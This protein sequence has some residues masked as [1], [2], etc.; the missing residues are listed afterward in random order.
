MSWEIHWDCSTCGAKI[1]AQGEQAGSVVLCPS[2]CT[3]VTVP[4]GAPAL[5]VRQSNVERLAGWGLWY[6]YWKLFSIGC[7]IVF[8][9]VV[10]GLVIL[11]AQ[12]NKDGPAAPVPVKLVDPPPPVDP[13]A[14]PAKK[15]AGVRTGG[16]S[17]G[18]VTVSFSAGNVAR[19]KDRPRI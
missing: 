17:A 16:Q 8:L 14:P 11:A 10:I 13:P 7:G 15:P 6:V 4:G 18:R 12:N 1:M 2:C 19:G 5:P 9:A 3:R